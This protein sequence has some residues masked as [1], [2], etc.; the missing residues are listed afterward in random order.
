MP[1][2]V[3]CRPRDKSLRRTVVHFVTVKWD[4]AAVHFAQPRSDRGTSTLNGGQTRDGGC[5]GGDIRG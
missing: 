4:K 5:L 2:S 3:Q 1:G